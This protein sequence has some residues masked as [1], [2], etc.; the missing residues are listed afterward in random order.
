MMLLKPFTLI[1]LVGGLDTGSI[2][3]D[4]CKLLI[5]SVYVPPREKIFFE[6]WIGLKVGIFGGAPWRS[7]VR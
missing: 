5:V 7:S 1:G 6:F 2:Y 3:I 4:I